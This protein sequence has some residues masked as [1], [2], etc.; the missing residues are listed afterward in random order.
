MDLLLLLPILGALVL[1]LL[2]LGALVDFIDGAFVLFILG[3]FVDFILGAL[4][5]FI[6][7]AFVDFMVGALVDLFCKN[8]SSYCRSEKRSVRYV[9]KARIHHCCL[10]GSFPVHRSF[11]PFAINIVSFLH[12][13]PLAQLA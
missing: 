2:I 8:R 4:V 6:E 3:A 5:D 9:R 1:L 10:D 13:H 12:R 11:L 7:G